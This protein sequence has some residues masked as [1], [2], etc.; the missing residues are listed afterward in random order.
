MKKINY[1]TFLPKNTIY[2][3]ANIKYQSSV[4]TP[5]NSTQKLTNYFFGNKEEEFEKIKKI[6]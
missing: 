4:H 6:F 5:K 2:I 1:F 3:N